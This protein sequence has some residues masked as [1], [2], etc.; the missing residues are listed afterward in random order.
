MM[1]MMMWEEESLVGL[2]DVCVAKQRREEEKAGVKKNEHSS[3]KA[4]ACRSRLEQ[5]RLTER[6]RP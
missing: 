1:M 4:E 6:Q 3:G 2:V 5:Y